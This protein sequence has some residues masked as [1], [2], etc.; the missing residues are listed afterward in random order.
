MDFSSA[1]AEQASSWIKRLFWKFDRNSWRCWDHTT[2]QCSTKQKARHTDTNGTRLTMPRQK[3]LFGEFS[4]VQVYKCILERFQKDSWYRGCQSNNHGW[5]ET[6]CHYLGF[7]AQIDISHK[8][9]YEQR[10]RFEQPLHM[11]CWES[12]CQLGPMRKRSDYHTAPKALV[13]L[14]TKTSKM[15]DLLPKEDRHRVNDPL[16]PQLEKWLTW[17]AENWKTHFA[18]PDQL[19]HSA[20]SS[21]SWDHRWWSGYSKW[22]WK[23]DDWT[24]DKWWLNK[25][26][27]KDDNWQAQVKRQIIRNR[28][29]LS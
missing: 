3:T 19:S 29:N 12:N 1:H 13:T 28:L 6:C 15:E 22:N 9:S 26:H 2:F 20:S 4:R 10:A 21:T 17:L 24:E 23:D 14:A 11:K 8:A 27:Q 16:S 7:I 5:T 25:Y 18:E